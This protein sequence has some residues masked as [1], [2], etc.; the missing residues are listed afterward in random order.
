MSYVDSGM[1]EE[2]NHDLVADVFAEL[3][4]ITPADWANMALFCARATNMDPDLE[5]HLYVALDSDNSIA[6]D[7]ESALFYDKDGNDDE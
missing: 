4:H 2:R 3:D 1:L 5:R 6:F 7:K